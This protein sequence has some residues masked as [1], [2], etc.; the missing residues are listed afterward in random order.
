VVACVYFAV[1]RLR[2]EALMRGLDAIGLTME[3][4]DAIR[5]FE[6]TYLATR[7]WLT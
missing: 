2:R 5:H 1:E 6:K 7:N 3:R 4:A